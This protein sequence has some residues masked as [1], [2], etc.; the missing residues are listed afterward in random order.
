MCKAAAEAG[1]PRRCSGDARSNLQRSAAEVSILEKVQAAIAGESDPAVFEPVTSAHGHTLDVM[2]SRHQG[3]RT[4]SVYCS[5]CR[6][7][8]T[9]PGGFTDPR[10]AKQWAEA[11]AEADCAPQPQ[12]LPR[13]TWAGFTDDDAAAITRDI[14][15]GIHNPV[16][17][18]TRY[19]GL[20]TWGVFC[21][22]CNDWISH[23]GGYG[24]ADPAQ[25]LANFH[26]SSTR[27]PNLPPV[28]E[29]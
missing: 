3:I 22:G 1:G 26:R 12:D 19:R 13:G 11:Y 28:A 9:P 7:W 25:N 27:T 24:Q 4:F 20:R 29:K 23:E 2:K 10:Q 8:V 17:L 14:A 5:G 15:A 21:P 16:V 6:Q 18:Q